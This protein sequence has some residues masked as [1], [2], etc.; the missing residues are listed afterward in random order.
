MTLIGRVTT[1][2][3]EHKGIPRL[4]FLVNVANRDQ[5]HG[6]VLSV[7]AEICFGHSQFVDNA[8]FLGYG[9]V[10]W[11]GDFGH[12]QQ[13]RWEVFLSMAHYHQQAVEERRRGRDLYFFLKLFYRAAHLPQPQQPGAQAYVTNSVQ[14]DSTSN[15][16]LT[17]KVAR[18]DWLGILKE[19]GWGDYFLIEVP[20]RGV[21][22]RSDFN[23]AL[24]HLT[25]AWKHF[26]DARDA[27]TIASCYKAFEFLASSH[28]FSNPDQQS[29]E[30]LLDGVE[31]PTKRRRIA[32]VIHQLCQY[33]HLGRHEAGKEYVQVDRRDAEYALVLTQATLRVLASAMARPSAEGP[34]G[35][36]PKTSKHG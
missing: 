29:F 26:G 13:D 33:F 25:E 31:D 3:P 22:A 16:F 12:K 2:L 36:R 8:D 20:L 24:D 35:R 15:G 19:L 9:S 1:I 32:L 7:T 28:G 10:Q 23:R 34:K 11:F 5:F 21:P 27:E 6:S 14:D 18:S 30:K 4:R 17:Y